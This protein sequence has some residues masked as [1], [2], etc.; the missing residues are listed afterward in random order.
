MII[1]S[2]IQ[3]LFRLEIQVITRSTTR[4]IA[5][6]ITNAITKTR[7]KPVQ[8]EHTFLTKY[9]ITIGSTIKKGVIF[10]ALLFIATNYLD[11]VMYF[12]LGLFILIT[13]KAS[14]GI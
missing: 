5:R 13:L 4:E 14:L 11:L 7:L 12:P 10:F 8:V 2:I 9:V 3:I 1:S 6:S